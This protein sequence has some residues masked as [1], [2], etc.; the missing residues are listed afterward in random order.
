LDRKEERE[1]MQDGRGKKETEES[2][3]LPG[4]SL[5]GRRGKR[6]KAEEMKRDLEAATTCCSCYHV[7]RPRDDRRL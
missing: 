7:R 4:S 1:R 5:A 3:L 2:G 6:R